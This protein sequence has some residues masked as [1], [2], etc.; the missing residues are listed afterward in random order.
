MFLRNASREVVEIERLEITKH[1]TKS[2][3]AAANISL[4]R[5]VSNGG[6]SPQATT[7][8]IHKMTATIRRIRIHRASLVVHSHV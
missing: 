7:L 8:K 5:P 3:G 2:A 1:M 4:R 6:G